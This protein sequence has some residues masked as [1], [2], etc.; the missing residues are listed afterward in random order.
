MTFLPSTSPRTEP[1]LPFLRAWLIEAV[2][3]AFP[4]KCLHAA[5]R[6]KVAMRELHMPM[7]RQ[8]G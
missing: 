5:E 4:V 1:P 6:A 2:A 7:Q 8:R 3:V